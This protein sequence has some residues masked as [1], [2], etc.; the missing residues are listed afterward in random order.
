MEGERHDATNGPEEGRQG[1]AGIQA[2]Q[3]A[4]V[5]R[6]EGPQAKAGRRHRAE[7]GTAI[8]RANSAAI[9]HAEGFAHTQALALALN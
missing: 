8:G 3:L 5:E 1:D 4:I 6:P 7:R 2:R 9:A